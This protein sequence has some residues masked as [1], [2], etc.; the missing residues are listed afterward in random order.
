MTEEKE[1]DVTRDTWFARAHQ[2]GAFAQLVWNKEGQSPAFTA[3]Y[4]QM[5]KCSARALA[6]PVVP[7]PTPERV[8]TIAEWIESWPERVW[9]R[10]RK[11]KG[12]R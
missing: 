11:A 5:A 7:L 2:A 12:S 9:F 1:P 6:M 3:W 4:E 10:N 8:P